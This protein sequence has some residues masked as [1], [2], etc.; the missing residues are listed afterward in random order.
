[1]KASCVVLRGTRGTVD[2]ISYTELF[3]K[4]NMVDL[5]RKTF[6]NMNILHSLCG[7]YKVLKH[8]CF[9]FELFA[10]NATLARR[11]TPP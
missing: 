9:A 1:M 11:V 4:R 7:M 10:M 5:Q 3:W 8:T 6:R 2:L